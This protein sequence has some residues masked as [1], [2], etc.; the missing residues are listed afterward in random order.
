MRDSFEKQDYMLELMRSVDK[1]QDEILEAVR[2]LIKIEEE[3]KA[4]HTMA[5]QWGSTAAK[6]ALSTRLLQDQEAYVAKYGST[7]KRKPSSI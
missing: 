7:G 5:P 6:S 2:K 3:K 1:K 4:E